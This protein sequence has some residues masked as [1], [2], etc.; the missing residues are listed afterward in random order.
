MALFNFISS[1][2]SE[3]LLSQMGKKYI[4]VANC[5]REF[6]GDIKNCGD[7]VK[8]CGVGDINV[9]DYTRNA[10]FELETQELSDSVKTLVIDQAKAFN[11]QID[12]I[13]RAQSNPKLMDAAV[14]NAAAALANTADQYV[15]SLCAKAGANIKETATV[16][17]IISLIIDA[18]TKLLENNV[19]DPADIVIEVSPAVGAL[20]LK[21]KINVANTAD[22]LIYSL[23]DKAGSSVSGTVTKDNVLDI[24]IDARTKLL[25]NNVCDPGDIVIEVSPEVSAF[26]LKGK[27]NASNNDT[28]LE[29]GCIGN[30]A[31]CKVYVSNNIVVDGNVHK[32]IAR[33]KRA[34]AFAEQLSEMDAY[35][36]EKRFADAV[37]G[38]HLYGAEVIYPS[39]M[40]RL[41][42]TVAA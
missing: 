18:Q 32:C 24:L 26:I 27:L 16:D 22:Q 19:C 14:K 36:P 25:E 3:S 15:F 11:F 17:N 21:N 35:R 5:N 34:I 37:K 41:D 33:S 8:I 28:A 30:V 29:T 40:V 13:D 12:D 39:E 4:A 42:L 6:E 31:G 1:V 9:F 20:I 38:L 10:D 2:W 23:C 7:R